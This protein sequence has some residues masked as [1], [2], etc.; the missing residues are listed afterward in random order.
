[1]DRI[2]Y[3]TMSLAAPGQG[4]EVGGSFTGMVGGAMMCSSRSV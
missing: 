3:A 2:G 1:M 4:V